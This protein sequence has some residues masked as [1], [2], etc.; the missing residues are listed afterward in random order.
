MHL[1]N[2]LQ[3]EPLLN[4]KVLGALILAEPTRNNPELDSLAVLH[5]D[6]RLYICIFN[7][8]LNFY[9]R[10]WLT[11]HKITL[12]TKHKITLDSKKHNL[13]CLLLKHAT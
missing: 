12:L 3:G 8:F 1:R 10:V 2:Q 7:N 9:Q 13:L 6:D 5:L 11:K 4:I